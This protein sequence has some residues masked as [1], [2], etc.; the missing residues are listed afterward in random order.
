MV[1]DSTGVPP[2][3]ATAAG[4]VQ[5]PY[6]VFEGPSLYGPVERIDSR[7]FRQLFA[8][9]PKRPLGFRFGYGDVGRRAHLIVTKRAEKAGRTA[10]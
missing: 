2:R 4:F 5:E 10:P 8:E 3:F 1:S 7:G 9:A 6:G